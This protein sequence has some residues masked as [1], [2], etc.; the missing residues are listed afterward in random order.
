LKI[1]DCN[2]DKPAIVL[3]KLPLISIQMGHAKVHG[4]VRD[5]LSPS[6][7]NIELEFVCE[8]FTLSTVEIIDKWYGGHEGAFNLIS[9]ID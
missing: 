4:T 8:L 2:D 3:K 9:E 1:K 6:E 5:Y 7:N